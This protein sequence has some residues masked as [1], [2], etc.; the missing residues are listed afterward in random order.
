MEGRDHAY[1]TID[2]LLHRKV[3]STQVGYLLFVKHVILLPVGA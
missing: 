2:P 3:H 1:D